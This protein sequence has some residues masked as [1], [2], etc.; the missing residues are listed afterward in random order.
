MHCRQGPGCRAVATRSDGSVAVAAAIMTVT[1]PLAMAV[2]LERC[3]HDDQAAGR[4][5]AVWPGGQDRAG[6][7]RSLGCHSTRTVRPSWR[8]CR[9]TVATGCP[10]SEPPLTSTI[11][12][13]AGRRAS[14]IRATALAGRWRCGAAGPDRPASSTTARA[15]ATIPAAASAA[16]RARCPV[17][18]RGRGGAGGGSGSGRPARVTG[19]VSCGGASRMAVPVVMASRSRPALAATRP[20]LAGRAA[21]PWPSARLPARPPR[22]VRPRAAGVADGPG[23]R[24]PPP[25][26]FR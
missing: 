4:H 25:L 2:G 5:L 24:A 20:A 9:R 19:K 6:G 21:G 14:G 13:T 3:G 16:A 18:T 23:A 10:A 7:W 1:V 22:W 12:L 26:G 17:R 11:E 15:A 8:S